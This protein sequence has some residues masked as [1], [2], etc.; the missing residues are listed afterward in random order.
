[1]LWGRETMAQGIASYFAIRRIEA[2]AFVL[3]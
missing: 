3:Y 1:M 2:R